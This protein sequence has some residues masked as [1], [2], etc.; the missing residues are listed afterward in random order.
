MKIEVMW[1]AMKISDKA[2]HKKTAYN[3]EMTVSIEENLSL[4][5]QSA[6]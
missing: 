5:R 3:V 6:K 4:K 1:K 2:K